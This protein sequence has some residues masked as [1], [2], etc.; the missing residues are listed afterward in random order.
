MHRGLLLPKVDRRNPTP[1]YLQA[2]EILVEAICAGRL[3][4][5]TKLPSTKEI[6]TLF[7]VSLITA[8]KALEGLVELGWLRR[9]VGRGTFVRDDVDPTAGVQ[10]QLF[11][12]LL[13]DHRDH[14]NIDD[15]YHGTILNQLR[16][17][18]R[19]DSRRVEFFFHDRFD[20][21]DKGSKQVGAICIHPPLEAQPD[22][23]RLAERRP[24]IVLGGTFAG[25]RVAS[26]D[27][28]NERGA[29]LAIRHLLQLG[30]R[31]F[32]ILSGPLNMSNSR[33]RAS[34][35]RA[36][37]VAHGIELDERDAL[38]AQDSVILDE[39][40]KSQLVRRMSAA[41]RPTAVVAGGFYLAMAAMQAIR[42]V[43]L[44]IPA[45]VSIV[46]FDDPASAPLLDPPLTT[47]R[48][49]L[50]EMA[51]RAYQLICRAIEERSPDMHGCQLVPELV[52]R[53]STGPAPA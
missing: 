50:E 33:D 13:L 5:G 29:R 37:L 11:V 41:D 14:V 27:C 43:G 25:A 8:H 49:P 19:A 47:M 48:Q 21:R 32:M 26:V 42:Q 18:A 16:R 39:E 20:L 12:G 31:R 22:V 1:K 6:S 46:G 30:H 52:V 24:V 53:K 7:D 45:D 9:E 3:A 38:V 17:E 44:S 15:Y 4:P 35:A 36:E 23:E 51:A 28:N 34:G 40:T 2:R 10:R